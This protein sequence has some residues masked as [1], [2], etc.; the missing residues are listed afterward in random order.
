MVVPNFLL[1]E[2]FEGTNV[3]FACGDVLETLEFAQVTLR[4]CD[5]W[6]E[7]CTPSDNRP[8]LLARSGD[9]QRV[10][11]HQW[12]ARN[13]RMRCLPHSGVC[14]DELHRGGTPLPLEPRLD[15]HFSTRVL[16]PCS[17]VNTPPLTYFDDADIKKVKITRA[18]CMFIAVLALQGGAGPLRR[19]TEL[20]SLSRNGI[21]RA[22]GHVKYTI[23]SAVDTLI[24]DSDM[25]RYEGGLYGVDANVVLNM[26]TREA[27]VEM[28][29]VVLGGTLTGT[30]RLESSTAESGG[31][32]LDEKLAHSLARRYIT[33]QT[34]SLDRER[35]SVCVVATVPLLGR[36]EIYLQ[37]KL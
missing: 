18:L 11:V 2:S 16:C 4:L 30:G 36:I 6:V 1:V 22:I 7:T 5:V 17:H 21:E 27:T 26:K 33:I 9:A 28:S 24:Q 35:D 15:R 31:V 23:M 29:G 3:F 32:V 19:R 25:R 8:L 12:C 34:A 14:L 10:K 13:V 20:H 37:R